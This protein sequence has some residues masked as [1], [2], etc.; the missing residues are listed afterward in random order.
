MGA[1]L[2][3]IF[4]G[5]SAI[6]GSMP[7]DAFS[8]SC[9]AVAYTVLTGADVETGLALALPIGTVMVSFSGILTPLFA[10]LVPFWE[11]LAETDIK[12]FELLN[13][14]FTALI[15]PLSQSLIMFVS[16]AYGVEGLNA[17]LASMPAW[18]TTGLNAASSMMLAV[19]FAILVSMIW[20]KEIGAF[21]FVGVVV[22]KFSHL[23]SLAVALLAAA[24][25]I[26]IYFSEKRTIDL[27]NQILKEV[28]TKSASA[29]SKEED[30]F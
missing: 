24:T 26:T 11:K 14:L 16:I 28:K 25:A 27:K 1:G 18:V 4:M 2:E 10:Q 21:F 30:F 3:S 5:V 23:S 8:A 19:G 15:A 6:G 17:F 12:K 13:G 9:I 29:D 22:A 20:N 7:A